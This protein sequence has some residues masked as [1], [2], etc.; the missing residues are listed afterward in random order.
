MTKDG[1]TTYYHT[2]L[3]GTIVK[4]GDTTVLPVMGEMIGNEDGKEKQDCERNAMKRWIGKH[5]QEC[6]WLKPTLLGDGLFPN[7]PVCKAVKEKCLSFIFACKEGSHPRLA[8]TVKNPY[9]EEKTKREWNG[10]R[11]PA[12]RYRRLSGVDIRDNKETLK[13]NYAY[14]EI[15]NGE[16]KKITCR[17]SWVTDKDV[18]AD[19]VMHIAPC[20]R[21]RRKIE[22]GH[23]NVLKN[24]G[25]NLGHNFGHGENRASETYCL[26]N[27]P[28][29]LFHGI[30]SLAD[31]DYRQA[32]AK[33]GRRAEFFIRMRAGLWY[34]LHEGWTGFII[35]VKTGGG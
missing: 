30:L 23:N 20:A 9:L 14:M 10:R 15:E 33:T 13:V 17:N 8:E 19:N 21:A 16:K 34:A 24:R 4:P 2:V 32:R 18:N 29:F 31:G 26:L 25:Y 12:Y 35:F 6:Q 28:A 1:V 11:H 22:N 7:Y 27:L 3:A 5:A